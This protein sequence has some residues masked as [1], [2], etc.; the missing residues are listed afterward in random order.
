MR[1]TERI[2]VLLIGGGVA[3]ARCARTLRRHRFDGSILLVGAEPMLPYNRPP[4]SKE[5]LRDDLPDELVLA[6]PDAWYER[7][8]VDVRVEARVVDLDANAQ[9]ASF[10]DGTS[11]A[12]ERCLLATGA[13]PRRLPIDGADNALLLRT[14]PDARAI[15]DRAEAAGARAAVTII[16][17]G[18]IGV[19]VASSLAALGLHPTI[20]EMGDGLWGRQLGPELG[21]WAIARLRA[22]G[23]AVRLGARVTRLDEA[24]AWIGEERM[25]HA[26]SVAGIGVEPR[27]G[28]AQSAGLETDDGVVTDAE[29]RTDHPAIWAAGDVARVAGIRVEHWHAAREGGERAA[30][31]MLGLAV[32]PRRASWVFSEVAGHQ[33][34]IVGSAPAWDEVRWIGDDQRFALAYSSAGLVRQVAIVDAAVPVEEARA[35]VEGGARLADVERVS[36]EARRV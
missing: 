6:E 31:G 19:E 5:L 10:D 22:A 28:L 7:R 18:F 8:S 1:P 33:L 27:I 32:P 2:D 21:E 12:F 9:V 11:I 35:L 34:D 26:F 17:G 25:A 30:L 4:L 29:Q 16:G 23:I 13:E 3:S 36:F 14:M 20:L 24:G 15:R